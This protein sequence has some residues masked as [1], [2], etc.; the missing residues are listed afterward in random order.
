M[1]VVSFEKFA[2]DFENSFERNSPHRR[3]QG[4]MAE[5]SP[6][7]DLITTL[8]FTLLLDESPSSIA[9]DSTNW[10]FG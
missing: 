8:I 6:V 3:I 1:Q 5:Y 7:K 4:F 9:T 2:C 10:K